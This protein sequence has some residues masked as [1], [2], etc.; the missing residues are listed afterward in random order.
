M[1]GGRGRYAGSIGL[2]KSFLAGGGLDGISPKDLAFV[3]KVVDQNDPPTRVN[4]LARL[5]GDP[6]AKESEHTVLLALYLAATLGTNIFMM[7]LREVDKKAKDY[8]KLLN[9]KYIEG[10]QQAA[11]KRRTQKFVRGKSKKGRKGTRRGGRH[12]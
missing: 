12:K 4:D 9:D 2:A 3:K 6:L 10:W 8:S 1:G 5:L 7:S 11:G